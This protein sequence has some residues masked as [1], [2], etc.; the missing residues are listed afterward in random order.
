MTEMV[1][2]LKTQ[3]QEV[4]SNTV[5]NEDILSKMGA[6]ISEMFK[7]RQATFQQ[8]LIEAYVEK[9]AEADKYREQV[10]MLLSG[11]KDFLKIADNLKVLENE[12]AKLKYEVKE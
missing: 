12:N 8:K 10:E 4:A 6:G 2:L 9:Q 7:T 5:A 11:N 3:F 1:R